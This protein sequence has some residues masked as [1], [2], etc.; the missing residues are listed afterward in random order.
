MGRQRSLI[1]LDLMGHSPHPPITWE[2]Q[3][4][5]SHLN[6][7]VGPIVPTSF[8]GYLMHEFQHPH[9]AERACCTLSL[10]PMTPKW[11]KLGLRPYSG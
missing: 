11:Q 10:A 9:V 3:L 8:P 5:C 6:R 7:V 4:G 1:A 2:D